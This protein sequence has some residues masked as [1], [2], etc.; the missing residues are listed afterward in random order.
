MAECATCGKALGDAGAHIRLRDKKFC[1]Q[2]AGDAKESYRAHL[3]VEARKILVATTEGLEGY[4]ITGYSGTIF[5]ACVDVLSGYADAVADITDFLGLGGGYESSIYKLHKDAEHKLRVV[6]A[7]R[8]AQ[9]V[10]GTHFDLELVEA[11]DEKSLLQ[12]RDRKIMVAASGT[13][14]TIEPH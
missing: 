10:V 9:A 7:H 11:G 14:V 12:T 4:R 5:A 6:A 3:L 1:G 13:A 2:C 8:G